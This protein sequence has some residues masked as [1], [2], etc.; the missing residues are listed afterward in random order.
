MRTAQGRIT[1]AFSLTCLALLL[2]VNRA[3]P[4][5]ME[6]RLNMTAGQHQLIAVLI[7]FFQLSFTGIGIKLP[8]LY[9]NTKGSLLNF[10]D[11]FGKT[12]VIKRAV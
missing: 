5:F 3:L 2:P 6:G 11:P 12:C 10:N 1:T 8:L 9:H 4:V 7:T